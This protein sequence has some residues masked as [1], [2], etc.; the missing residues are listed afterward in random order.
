MFLPL[1][2][3]V[4]DE[5]HYVHQPCWYADNTQEQ[6]GTSKDYAN[7]LK[8]FKK[9]G[10]AVGTNLPEASLLF[11]HTPRKQPRTPSRISASLLYLDPAT[12]EASSGSL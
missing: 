2:Q 3:S 5:I 8:S 10:P 12:S 7:I 9:K 1:I 6:G 4:K 11:R